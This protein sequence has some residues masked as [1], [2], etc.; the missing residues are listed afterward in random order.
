MSSGNKNLVFNQYERAI[1]NDLNRLQSFGAAEQGETLRNLLNKY[2]K[3]DLSAGLDSETLTVST[4]LAGDVLGG[5]LVQPQMGGANITISAG[6]LGCYFPDSSPTSDDS[7]YKV[8]SDPGITLTGAN[9]IQANP[10]VYIRI[11]VIECQPIN[12]VALENDNRDIYNPISE[13]F[14]GTNV[15][16]V[17]T[18]KLTYRIR[19]GIPGSGFPANQSGWLP[20][21]VASVPAGYGGT[22]TNSI[23]FWDVRPLVCDLAE[24]MAKIDYAYSRNKINTTTGYKF[25]TYL[26]ISGIAE[27]TLGSYK[28]GGVTFDPSTYTDVQYIDIN[29]STH[30]EAGFSTLPN[31]TWYLY[32]V[33]PFN[34]PRWVIYSQHDIANVGYRVPGSFRGIPIVSYQVC[35]SNGFIV[36]TGLTLPSSFGLGT[37]K[38]TNAVAI[39]SG[40]TDSSGNMQ[41]YANN[42]KLQEFPY[43]YI[44]GEYIVPGG[45]TCINFTPTSSTPAFL[46]TVIVYTPDGQ[47][48][49]LTKNTYRFIPGIDFPKNATELK[50]IITTINKFNAPI[51]GAFTNSVNC[52]KEVVIIGSDLEATPLGVV[53]LPNTNI[54]INDLISPSPGTLDSY[55][56]TDTTTV[57]IPVTIPIY[58]AANGFS[59]NIN[60]NFIIAGNGATSVF[61]NG[62]ALKITGWSTT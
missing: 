51:F 39:T 46:S 45:T 12:S 36:G 7:Q 35:D 16:K 47:G 4:P 24:P 8:V 53:I 43:S 28:A 13:T 21:A 40:I 5:L 62:Q 49:L 32:V 60:Y 18:S 50:L 33:H 26:L 3:P 23:T 55:T 41:G 37:V 10:S 17:H 9:T 2:Y 11:D 57:V 20:L 42:G 56:W 38:C 44:N 52:Q 1:S 34:L 14:V 15:T 19:Q 54:L 31:H 59:I 6:K 22:N 48:V 61:I 29:L 27:A 30:Q 25:S 58:L